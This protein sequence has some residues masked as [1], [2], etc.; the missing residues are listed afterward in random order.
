[1][2]ILLGRAKVNIE[3]AEKTYIAK[4]YKYGK[5]LARVTNAFFDKYN[6]LIYH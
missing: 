4:Y 1:M 5:E 3:C 6:N 2:D